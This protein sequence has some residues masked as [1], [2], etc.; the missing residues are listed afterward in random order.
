MNFR[1]FIEKY[2]GADVSALALQRDRLEKETPD[3]ALALGTLESRKKIKDKLPEWYSVTSLRLPLPLSAEQCSS[4][5]TAFYKAGLIEGKRVADLTG[6]LGVDSWAFSK[7]TPEVL[8]NDM[9]PVLAAAAAHNFKELGASDI[10]IVSREVKEGS[11]EEILDGFKPDVIYLDPAR[12]SREGRKVF[13]LE[14]CSPNVASILPELYR[15]CPTILLKLSPMADIT[16]LCRSLE[17]V[18]EVHIVESGGECKEL[19]LLLEKGFEGE[20]LITATDTIHSFTFLRSEEEDSIAISGE[21]LGWLF[22]PGKALA[23]AGAFRLLSARFKLRKMQVNT[24]LYTADGIVEGLEGL[25][26]WFRISEVLPLDKRSMKEVGRRYPGAEVS[27]RNI[28]LSAD[29]LRK[30]TGCK[31]GGMEHIFGVK[32]PQGNFLLVT[33]RP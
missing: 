13:R 1:D 19:L 21:P 3:F 10:R 14:D 11:I 26:K 5:A 25:G 16:L 6:G 29:E 23:K 27:A 32:T 22:E 20:P 2:D 12:R 15:A 17:G 4:Q 33:L 24:H 28:P 31:G 18:K 30:R 8:Y 7:Y 9:N